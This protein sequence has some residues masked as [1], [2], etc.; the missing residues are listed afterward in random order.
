MCST[1]MASAHDM[2]PRPA[3]REMYAGTIAPS[4]ANLAQINADHAKA[5]ASNNI[6]SDALGHVSAESQVWASILLT[7]LTKHGHLCPLMWH[8][9]S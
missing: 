2:L 7:N 9:V 5:R 3:T 1:S 4:A 8:A 6:L